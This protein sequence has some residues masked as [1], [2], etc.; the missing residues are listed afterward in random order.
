MGSRVRRCAEQGPATLFELKH[1]CP[2]AASAAA[3]AMRFAIEDLPTPAGPSSSELVPAV[4]PPP[5]SASKGAL[6]VFRR[7]RS[8]TGMRA[9]AGDARKN[10]QP[11]LDDAHVMDTANEVGATM[12]DDSQAAAFSAVVAQ[13]VLQPDH[14]VCDA[15]QM[16]VRVDTRVVVQ[17]QHRTSAAGEKLFERKDLSAIAQRSRRQQSHLGQRIEDHPVGVGGHHAVQYALHRIAELDLGRLE[18]GVLRSRLH[19]RRRVDQL[20]RSIPLSDHPCDAAMPSSSRLRLRERHIQ[21]RLAAPTSLEQELQS[22]RGLTGSRHA[23][24]QIEPICRQPAVQNFVQ[25]GNTRAELSIESSSLIRIHRSY[26]EEMSL[27]I[28][29]F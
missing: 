4:S 11:P 15:L 27:L 10:L 16:L 24:N 1:Q 29:S 12:F 22:Q 26:P 8:L 25:W 18:H 14:A 2:L 23:F 17:Q 19:R 28:L 5:S 21:T 20:M 6:P 9:P 13:Q 3:I 7:S